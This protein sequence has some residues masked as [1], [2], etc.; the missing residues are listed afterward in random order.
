MGRLLVG[1]G[2]ARLA[3]GE[4]ASGREALTAAARVGRQ[5]GD[6][7]LLAAAALGFGPSAGTAETAPPRDAALVAVLADAIA[8]DGLDSSTTARLHARL[9]LELT[10]SSNL[11][12]TEPTPGAATA[13]DVERH[14]E[15]A[16][17][18]ARRSG[19][20]RAL[21]EAC[22]ATAAAGKTT[23]VRVATREAVALGDSTLEC[24][25]HLVS[26]ERAF[27]AGDIGAA[28]RELTAVCGLGGHPYPV[29]FAAVA[30]AHRALLAGRT[31]QSRELAGAALAAG[32]QVGPH[33][34][35]LTHATQLAAIQVAEGRVAELA[36]TLA[37]L[38]HTATPPQWLAALSAL[39][40]VEQGELGVARALVAE[41]LESHDGR[42]LWTAAVLGQVAA[43]LGDT[44]V[45]AR[46][47]AHL[48][49]Y[50]KAWIVIGP[51]VANGGPVA[52]ALARLRLVLGDLTAAEASLAHASATVGS[53]VWLPHVRLA[54][55]RLLAAGGRSGVPDGALREAQA[56][57]VGAADRGLRGLV[58][59]ADTLL[60][61]LAA[62]TGTGLTR[63]EQEVA[64]LAVR[65]AS[66]REIAEQLVIGERTV[67]THLANIYR[68]LNVRSRVELMARFAGSTVRW[69]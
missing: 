10:A 61:E 25:A 66:A 34:A 1:V 9:A 49:P 7:G 13:A 41:V 33:A 36:P 18:A 5:T 58:D 39:V 50:E 27:A 6:T 3:C 17:D 52:L 11:R 56:A 67:E 40:A 37:A 32:R 64:A 59:R 22:L 23:D 46:L 55:A 62:H 12:H 38:S 63:R 54:R 28:D 43:E 30:T 45:A 42:S 21:A 31:A 48:A 14:A 68:K 60:G 35:E 15:A 65:G 29:W 47:V 8:G 53:T 20:P 57:R 26:A 4:V 44:A 69:T 19:D 24:R 16:T 51:A 2:V